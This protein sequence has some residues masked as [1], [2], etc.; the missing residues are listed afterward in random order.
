ML[1]SSNAL[2][3]TTSTFL[4]FPYNAFTITGRKIFVFTCFLQM[5][6]LL[7]LPCSCCFL[8]VLFCFYFS[9]TY[10]SAPIYNPFS[11][12]QPMPRF[13]INLP[14]FVIRWS[15]RVCSPSL[16]RF[17]IPWPAP[18]FSSS[19]PQ[20]VIPNLFWVFYPHAN[21]SE[22]F[23]DFL[24]GVPQFVIISPTSPRDIA[25]WSS[26]LDKYS[27]LHVWW[28]HNCQTWR[29]IAPV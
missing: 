16:N 25:T 27:F 12:L 2:H 20:F 6:W 1:L 17:V 28:S 22:T 7:L 3:F 4:L 5:L 19:L 24:F 29:P 8:A 13:L 18:V 21:I 10:C 26:N 11:T 15:A 23:Y 14:R 9:T